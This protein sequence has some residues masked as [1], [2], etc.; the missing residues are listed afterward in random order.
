MILP[1]LIDDLKPAYFIIDSLWPTLL[2]WLVEYSF[3]FF[4]DL[5]PSLTNALSQQIDGNTRQ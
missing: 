1:K 2:E 4:Q 3:I 5:K